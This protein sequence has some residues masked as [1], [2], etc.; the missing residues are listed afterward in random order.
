MLTLFIMYEYIQKCFIWFI[1]A[2]SR[3]QEKEIYSIV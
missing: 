2:T 3:F 1:L